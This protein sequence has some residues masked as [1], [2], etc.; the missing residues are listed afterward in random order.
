MSTKQSLKLV[1]S[2]CLV[3]AL[4]ATATLATAATPTKP[5]AAAAAGTQTLALLD[6]KLPLT[7]QGFEPRPVPGGGPGTMYYKKDVK[8]VVIVG[9]EPVPALARGGSEQDVLDGMKAI[10]AKQQA[11]SPTYKVASEKTESVN[12][13]KVHHIEA[14]DNMGGN[15]VLQATLLATA[16]KKF[17]VIQVISGAKD[18][19]GHAAAVNKILAK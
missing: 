12:G 14:T 9:E 4:S 19:A 8:R 1:G 6:G 13:L 15:D 17:V 16:N 10:K 11:A 7:L 3:A 18:P 5:A 2:L